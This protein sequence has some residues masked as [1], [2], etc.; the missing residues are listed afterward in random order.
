MISK[1][2]AG[3]VL[4]TE[5]TTIAIVGN[6]TKYNDH[7]V[8]NTSELALRVKEFLY[9]QG[10][11]QVSSS[12][13]KGVSTGN[14]MIHCEI[15]KFYGFTAVIDERFYADSEQEAIFKAGDFMLEAPDA[16]RQL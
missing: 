15:T 11:D 4:G 13:V 1:K 8:I 3:A 12:V 9:E 7:Y 2:L 16:T 10:L 14:K 6:Q 5:V